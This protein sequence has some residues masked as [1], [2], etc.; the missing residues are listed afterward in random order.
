MSDFNVIK[1]GKDFE[2]VPIEPTPKTVEPEQEED[3][4]DDGLD[5]ISET[6]NEQGC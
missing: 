2:V 4:V 1:R 5:D 3:T 6:I